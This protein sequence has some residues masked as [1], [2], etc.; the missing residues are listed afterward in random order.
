[1]TLMI[2]LYSWMANFISFL[3]EF[4]VSTGFPLKLRNQRVGKISISSETVTPFYDRV[5][6]MQHT[7]VMFVF[8]PPSLRT[9]SS[10]TIFA[11]TGHHKSTA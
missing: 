2:F 4:I 6:V 11:H 3:P 9:C 8:P 10:L 7:C 5:S 1:M